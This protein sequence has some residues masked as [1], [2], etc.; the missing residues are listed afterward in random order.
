MHCIALH[1][2]C[3]CTTIH[4]IPKIVF[5][6]QEASVSQGDAETVLK[7]ISR[8][9]SYLFRHI[10]LVPSDLAAALYLVALRQR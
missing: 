9:F 4:T 8:L 2:I 1:C 3:I 10:D 6:T 5:F 7:R